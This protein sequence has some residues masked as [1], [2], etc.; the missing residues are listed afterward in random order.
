MKPRLL[1]VLLLCVAACG[2]GD[3]QPERPAPDVQQKADPAAIARARE[4]LP[5]L[6]EPGVL[7]E[8]VKLRAV[9]PLATAIA[10]G[11]GDGE[12]EE[13]RRLAC[14]AL[15]EIGGADA[16]AA[17]LAI[18]Q[19]PSPDPQRDGPMRLYAAAGLERLADPAT[20][21][22]LIEAL[23]KVNPN[24]NVVAIGAE[25][26]SEEYY[27]VD[28]QICAALLALGLWTAEEDLVE[29]MRRKHRVRVLIDA[30]ALLRRETGFDLPFHYNGSY[31]DRLRQAE[32]WRTKLRA[33]R[34]EREAQRGFVASNETFIRDCRRVV[35]WLGGRSVNNR[36]IARKVLDRVGRYAQPYLEEALES[37]RPVAQRQ[38]A[39]MMGR[40]GH[41]G[42]AAALRKA[43]DLKDA[44]A[45]AE[46]IDG[47]RLVGDADSLA[48]VLPRLTDSDPEVRAASAR[49]L[50]SCGGAPER[51][52]LSDAVGAETRPAARAAMLMALLRLGDATVL[53]RVLGI[54]VNGEQLEREAAETA[55][56]ET[57]GRALAA[58][59]REPLEQRRAAAAAFRKG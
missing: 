45:R 12:D 7:D 5:R 23:S 30:Y 48:L 18:L 54:F 55:L 51:T 6:A 32:A 37:D 4:L 46:A 22:P 36:L 43:T 40:I 41:R 50:G 57:S 17:L 31:E 34:A 20:A 42:A 2:D 58:G 49:Y 14:V 16:R 33:T 8:V 47:L 25:E 53:D 21:I 44:D 11:G 24:D 10:E 52:A 59:A 39:Y 15:G 28:A 27:T 1:L 19:G 35:E 3:S 9:E 26:R 29:Q 56:E 13:V 38:A